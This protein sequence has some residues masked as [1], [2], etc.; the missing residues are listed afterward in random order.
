MPPIKLSHISYGINDKAI[1][2]DVSFMV[3]KGQFLTIV[4]PNGAGKTTLLKLIVGL[5]KPTKG[6][7]E[8]AE[9]LTIGYV[10]QKLMVNHLMPL[11]VSTFLNL[12]TTPKDKGPWIARFGIEKILDHMVHN[13][14]GGEF[15]RVLLARALMQNPQLLIL[16]EPTQGL[17][18]QAQDE[19]YG[20]LMDLK[21]EMGFSVIMVSHDLH[22]VH[23]ASDHVICLN[24]HICC[25]GAPRQIVDMKE[26]QSMFPGHTPPVLAAYAHSHDHVHD[27]L[28]HEGCKHDH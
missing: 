24:Q 14:S 11:R 10:P 19:F 21:K 25:A 7:I 26:Y 27:E 1:L 4:G 22:L 18:S 20:L 9:D 5:I 17:D 2:K 13:L 15:Q 6:T 16:D 12:S 3:E 23:R 28:N 8:K